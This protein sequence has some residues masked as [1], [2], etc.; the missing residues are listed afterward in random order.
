[1]D[2]T[3]P[4]TLGCKRF[5]RR[6]PGEKYKASTML[7]FVSLSFES[8]QQKPL[9][10][11]GFV[12]VR[13]DCEPLRNYV[14][15]CSRDATFDVSPVSLLPL[16]S[17]M[18]GI[19]LWHKAMV[20]INLKAKSNGDTCEDVVLV[21]ACIDF[22]W[23]RIKRGKVL[24]SRIDG[25]FGTLYMDYVF[26]K[27]GIEAVVEIDI[28]K[29]LIGCHV[30][31][32]ARNSGFK[33]EVM[34]YDAVVTEASSKVS[35]V[36]AACHRGNLYFGF[37]VMDARAYD[38]IT[39][40]DGKQSFGPTIALSKGELPY[41]QKILGIRDYEVSDAPPGAPPTAV[42]VP[43]SVTFSTLGYHNCGI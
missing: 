15:N 3:S 42:K 16:T 32:L 13:D 28:P 23:D 6:N 30:T 43:F 7:Q 22:R 33:K 40:K 12:A 36:I 35:A 10:I 14:F 18:R 20:E 8:G 5:T 19:S 24:K 29:N 4:T 26:I 39:F 21:D 2:D 17:P 11:Y 37:L 27:H 9:S 1:M 38:C 41:A 31:I 34:I 25:P